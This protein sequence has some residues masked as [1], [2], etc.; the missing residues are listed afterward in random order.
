[1]TETMIQLRRNNR[2][3]HRREVIQLRSLIAPTDISSELALGITCGTCRRVFESYSDLFSHQGRDHGG[4]LSHVPSAPR[5]TSSASTS[6]SSSSSSSSPFVAP[7]SP[8]VFKPEPLSP[9]TG[10]QEDCPICMDSHDSSDIFSYEACTNG[11]RYCLLCLSAHLTTQ[12]L[13]AEVEVLQCPHPGCPASPAEYEVRSLVSPD[14][15]EK[16]LRFVLLAFLQTDTGIIWCPNPACASPLDV[17]DE[18]CGVAGCPTC[19]TSIC[20]KCNK[21][22]HPSVSCEG[23]LKPEEHLF[24]AWL[25]EKSILVKPC[26]ECNARIEKNSG[27]FFSSSSSS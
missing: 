5:M 3:K 26:P 7:V 8:P 10:I 20:L 13:D 6:S 14:T 16:Y 11:H 22:Y 9:P 19:Q 17:T 4:Q 12:I 18:G 1:M 21:I 27:M 23:A 25:S 2:R 24:Q 15:Y